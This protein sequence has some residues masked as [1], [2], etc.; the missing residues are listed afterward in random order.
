[1]NRDKTGEYA[2][3]SVKL[4]DQILVT[5]FQAGRMMIVCLSG[6]YFCE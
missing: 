3:W 2:E 4:S 1:M 5:A 6:I